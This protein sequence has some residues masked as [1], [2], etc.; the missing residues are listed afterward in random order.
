M[1]RKT[2]LT[3]AII[4]IGITII[5]LQAKQV[6]A[7][8]T[9]YKITDYIEPFP[10][11]KGS[12]FLEMKID[13]NYQEGNIILA[14]DEAG[15]L[16][17]LV[18]DY[19]NI[20]VVRPDGSIKIFTN[21]YQGGCI[22]LT[23]LPPTDITNLF[24]PG[25]NQVTVR[26]NDLCGVKASSNPI[27]ILNQGLP[28]PDPIPF[29]ILPWDY[30]SHN[31][32]FSEAALQMTSYFDHTYPVLSSGFVFEP[33]EYDK[34]VTTFKNISNSRLDYSSHDGYDYGSDASVLNNEPALAAADGCAWYYN[35]GPSGHAILIDHGNYYQTRL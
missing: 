26:L 8:A 11:V 31:L 24:L 34:Q 13:V 29:L 10:I 16:P 23:P 9:V 1:N 30:Q 7:L 4:F 33:I 14:G 32:S 19:I 5:G 21:R 18:D 35:N 3:I 15:S 17:T 20:R 27:Y 6:S 12:N 22:Q 25:T 28:D 2:V